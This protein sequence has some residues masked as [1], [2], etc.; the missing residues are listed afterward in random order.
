MRSGPAPARAAPAA[1][2]GER[3]LTRKERF[4]RDGFLV[5]EG[6]ASAEEVAALRERA[7]E[8]AEAFVAPP[9]E[10]ASVFSTTQQERTT[11]AT[12]L[13]SAATV[14]CFMEE[15]ARAEDGTLV[16]DAALCINKIGHA[17][18]D[19]DPT[20]RAFSRS[21][22]VEALLTELGVVEPTP[23][24]SMYIFK[25]PSIGGEVV[26]HQ[27]STFLYTE[28]M[29]TVGLWW[30]LEDATKENGCLWALPGSHHDGVARRMLVGEDK[31]ITF[32]KPP[33][34]YDLDEFVPLEV[35]A[36]TLVVLHGENVHA[37]AEN[38]SPLS[39]HAYSVHYVSG[40]A[41]WQ[42]ENWL[43]RPA[44]FPFQPLGADAR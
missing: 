4:A 25:Q 28:P 37:S 20:F 15:K 3:R 23:V 2:G 39:R 31:Q 38:T 43:Q 6:F 34:E 42:P 44:D 27:D 8:I 32:D 17:M 10:E 33:A 1:P 7:V 21:E 24:Q 35:P 16:Q 14:D 22:K 11:D 41:A 26:P 5:V 13:A 12:F 19:L 30:A 36:G 29:S 9:A 40:K 18:H